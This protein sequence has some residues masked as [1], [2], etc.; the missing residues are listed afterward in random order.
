MAKFKLRNPFAICTLPFAI[1]LLAC[2]L[3]LVLCKQR[4]SNGKIQIVESICHLHFAIC[5]LPS[6]YFA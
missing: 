5:H 3:C 1:A 4:T 2:W 6:P